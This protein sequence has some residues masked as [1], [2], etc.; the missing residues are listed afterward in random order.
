MDNITLKK[1]TKFGKVGNIVVTACLV[2]VF[3]YG[4]QL[5]READETL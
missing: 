1:V 3:R 4:A 5:Q 2:T